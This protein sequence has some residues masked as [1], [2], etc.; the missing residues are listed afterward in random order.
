MRMYIISVMVSALIHYRMG[1]AGRSRPLPI[2]EPADYAHPAHKRD[3][4][5]RNGVGGIYD[6]ITA[7]RQRQEAKWAAPH[8]WG[9]G[10]CSS[11]HVDQTVKATVLGEEY[12]EV[13]RAILDANPS[14][15]KTELVQL[16]AVAVAMLEGLDP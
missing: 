10:D 4:M 13:C 16:A 7:E 5:N 14:S 11:P 6:L 9:Q 2:R 15:L 12:G 8:R 1:A 3:H